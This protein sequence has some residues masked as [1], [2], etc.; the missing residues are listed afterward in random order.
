MYDHPAFLAIGA[1]RRYLEA[2]PM[3]A[4][5]AEV[6]PPAA[7]AGPLRRPCGY[8]T[9]RPTSGLRL[10]TAA[11]LRCRIGAAGRRRCVPGTRQPDSMLSLAVPIGW[12]AGDVGQY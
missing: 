6:A 5:L 4:R 7:R 1:L 2:Q 11:T 12:L 9:A 8:C 10:L 3:L